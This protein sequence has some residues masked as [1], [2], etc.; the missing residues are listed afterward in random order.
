MNLTQRQ[1]RAFLAVARLRHF[2]RAA[3]QLHITQAGLSAM[4]KDLEAQLD[5][6][7]FDRTTRSVALT[8]EGRQLVPVATRLVAELEA[9]RDAIHRVS[10]QAR[11]VLSVGVTP[12]IAASVMP[13]AW[14]AFSRLH[15]EVSLRV[16]DIGRQAIQEGVAAGALDV[17]FGAFFKPAS[18]LERR[19]IAVFSLARVRAAGRPGEPAPARAQ[20]RRWAELGEEPLLAL[21]QD[22]P[23]Q[24]LID[25]QLHRVGLGGCERIEFENIQTLLAMAEAG[26]GQAILPS[27]VAAAARRHALALSPLVEPE[28][29]V[30]YFQIT[31]KGRSPAPAVAGLASILQTVLGSGATG[32]PRQ[33]RLLGSVGA[34]DSSPP[35]PASPAAG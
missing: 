3:E 14:Q 20:R 17:G 6:R 33:H 5:C 8:D 13:A 31:R 15:P 34:R 27:F 26:V 23:I 30:S 7:L 1:M 29:P 22:N 32:S 10:S 35:S 2:T 19:P 11:S 4:M 18:G 28:V 25:E 24:L 9:V 12:T 16:R 21:P